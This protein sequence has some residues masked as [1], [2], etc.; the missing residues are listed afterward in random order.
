MRKKVLLIDGE[1]I[2]HQS[3]H[4]FEK[5]KSTDGKPSGAIFGFF[6][7][8]HMYMERF[9]PNYICISFDNGHSPYRLDL[10]PG[11]KSH[12]KN[13]SVDYESLQA[14]KEIIMRMLKYLRIPYVFDKD[15][16]TGYEG[17]DF[18]AWLRYEKYGDRNKYTQTLVTSD[19][20]YNQLITKDVRVFNPRK[21]EVITINNCKSL[22]GYTP[23]ETID[24][25]CLV[26]D[27]SDDIPGVKGYGPVKTRKFL[28]KYWWVDEAFKKGECLEIKETY[29]RNK[30]L[31]DLAWFINEHPL[32]EKDLPL[33]YLSKPI[34]WKK[35]KEVCIE[36]SLASFM[37][38]IF[39]KPFK[40]YNHE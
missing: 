21:N 6:K 35:F 8:L 24:Y 34:N 3:F 29:E 28:D 30:K 27:S 40:E 19:K 32:D 18:I 20:D 25:L 10:L 26:G 15:K 17:D 4:K 14:Q 31:I 37:T 11:Y 36:Y 9:Y 5:F 22:F 13:I 16:S 39:M 1:N 2:L 38:D 7:S 12:R 23:E 33:H